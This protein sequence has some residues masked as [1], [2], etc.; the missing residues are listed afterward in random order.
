VGVG[1]ADTDWTFEWTQNDGL[2][3][4]LWSDLDRVISQHYGA[5]DGPE[6]ADP[7]R[8]AFLLDAQGQ[9]LLEYKDDLVL[10]PSP[11]DLLSDLKKLNAQ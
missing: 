7:L 3:Y 9:V 5:A 11:G 8:Y 1:I 6:T 10:G 2:Q 4:E